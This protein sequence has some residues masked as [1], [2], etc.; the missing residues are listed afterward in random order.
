MD[1]GFG[2]KRIRQLELCMKLDI[3]F[4]G[5]LNGR[6]QLVIKNNVED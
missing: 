3:L 1:M 2:Q 5:K 6:H 4:V